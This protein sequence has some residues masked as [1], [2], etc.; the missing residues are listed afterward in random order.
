MAPKKSPVGLLNFP[1]WNPVSWDYVHY[2]QQKMI[3]F[4]FPITH[5]V[6]STS[7]SVFVLILIFV[8]Q[9]SVDHVV[10]GTLKLQ[11]LVLSVLFSLASSARWS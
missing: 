4:M 10:V 11:C 2:F 1:A 9:C 6:K 3:N 5:H 8:P 7:A